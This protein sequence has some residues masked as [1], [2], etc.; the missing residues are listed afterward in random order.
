MASVA[1]P[2]IFPSVRI[3]GEYY[4]DKQCVKKLHFRQPFDWALESLIIS[5]ESPRIMI[6]T[7][8]KITQIFLKLEDIFWTVYFPQPLPDLERLDRINQVISLNHN[9]RFKPIQR[10]ETYRLFGYFLRLILARLPRVVTKTCPL[11]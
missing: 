4:G 1:L 10:N 9:Q 5:T 6:L 11:V 2:L 3:D 7:L 8:K